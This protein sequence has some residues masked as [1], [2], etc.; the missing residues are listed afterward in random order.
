VRV[1][2]LTRGESVSLDDA[3]DEQTLTVPRNRL[4][5]QDG[6]RLRGSHLLSGK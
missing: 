4:E 2:Q 3:G 5:S 1:I 6:S